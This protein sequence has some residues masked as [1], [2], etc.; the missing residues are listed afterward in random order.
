MPPTTARALA[1][2]AL[3]IAMFVLALPWAHAEPDTQDVRARNR[4]ALDAAAASG[5]AV[6][7]LP[8]VHDL[9]APAGGVDPAEITRRYTAVAP[10]RAHSPALYVLVSLSVPMA[11]LQNLARDTARAGAVMLLRGTSKD[12]PPLNLRATVAALAPLSSTGAT[13][14]I[15]PTMFARFGIAAV[16][17][18]VLTTTAAEQCE[19]DAGTCAPFFAVAGDVPL[20][21][22]LQQ[23]AES[24]PGAATLAQ[25]FLARLPQ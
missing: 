20:R 14:Q 17:A 21:Y 4:D 8:E 2:A 15:H 23:L 11:S 22:A 19:S 10:A 12:A 16:P 25:Q 3:G 9:P 7:A 1:R 5:R 24:S 13:V 6:R 18:F